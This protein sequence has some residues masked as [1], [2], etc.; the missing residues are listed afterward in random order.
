[1]PTAGVDGAA[2]DDGVEMV[3]VLDLV[4]TEQA[5]GVPFFAQAVGDHLG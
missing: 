3:E 4:R 5:D 1:V 2:D